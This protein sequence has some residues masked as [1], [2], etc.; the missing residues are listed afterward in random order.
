MYEWTQEKE[1]KMAYGEKQTGCSKM[2]LCGTVEQTKTIKLRLS[3]NR[4][5]NGAKVEAIMHLAK[6]TKTVPVTLI[7][8]HLYGLSWSDTRVGVAILEIFV[9]GV[10][11]PESPIRVQVEPRNCDIDH[12]GE[13]KESTEAGDC[14]CESGTVD[15][16]DKCVQSTVLAI[17]ISIFAVLLVSMCGLCYL[18][19]QRAKNDA[20]WMIE[21]DELQFDDPVEVVGQGSFG[22]VLCAQYRGTKVAIKRALKN[23]SRS[24]RSRTG[25][26][27]SGSKGSRTSSGKQTSSIGISSPGMGSIDSNSKNPPSDPEAAD[28]E[29]ASTSSH[30]STATPKTPSHSTVGRNG[31]NSRSLGFLARDYGHYKWTWL[32]WARRGDYQSRFKEAILGVTGSASAASKTWHAM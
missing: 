29:S 10:M 15:L 31:T 24:R 32:P 12:P 19:Y 20:L 26:G 18:R 13:R 16:L 2:S 27:K 3:D 22:V 23:T 4:E 7:E 17:V 25:K 9:D 28:A 30:A 11:I 8:E 1:D 14:V 21:I 6:S 5:R